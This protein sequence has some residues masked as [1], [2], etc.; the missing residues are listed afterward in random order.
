MSGVPLSGAVCDIKLDGRDPFHDLCG[1]VYI[2]IPSFVDRFGVSPS[3]WSFL[4]ACIAIPLALIGMLRFLLIKETV[5]VSVRSQDGAAEKV[6]ISD[7][8]TVLT[9]NPYIWIVALILFVCN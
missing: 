1:G 4:I 5:D 9:K 7:V 6:A 2:A 8:K 3:G